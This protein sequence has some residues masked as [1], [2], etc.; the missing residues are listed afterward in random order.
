MRSA[1]GAESVRSCAEDDVRVVILDTAEGDEADA[2]LA[3][4]RSGDEKFLRIDVD[5]RG[6]V[7]HQ[8]FLGD[9][10]FDFFPARV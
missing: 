6:G 8:N 4:V 1:L 5:G 10:F 2:R 7:L 9:P 3:R